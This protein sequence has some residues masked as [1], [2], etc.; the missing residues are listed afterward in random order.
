M[1]EFVKSHNDDFKLDKSLELNDKMTID[2]NYQSDE[3]TKTN[4][5][6]SK[7]ESDVIE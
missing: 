2:K 5:T 1:K 7:K 6:L 3:L 4:Q